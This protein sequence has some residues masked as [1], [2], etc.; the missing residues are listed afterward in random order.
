MQNLTRTVYGS[1]LQSLELLGGSFQ[2]T[3]YT[4]LNEKFAI[5]GGV[6][7]AS[8]PEFKGWVIGNGGHTT[9][10]GT[11]NIPI[12]TPLQHEATDPCCFHH[13][14]FVLRELT[15]DLTTAQ[16]A[17]YALRRIEEW[18]GIAYAAY[19]A[20]R[21]DSSSI[22]PV[23]QIETVASDGTATDVV[24]APDST[25]LSPTAKQLSATGVNVATGQLA[26][27]TS[28]LDLSLDAFDITELLN[29][30]NVIYG[31]TNYAIISE[32]GLI[33]GVDK[34]ISASGSGA[35]TF[36]FNE[37]IAAQVIEF[38]NCMYPL[39]YASTGLELI[40][41]VGASEPLLNISNTTTT[42]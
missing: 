34:T 25:N 19:Y 38:V 17:N 41:D 28:Q 24:F 15:N 5:E 10:V 33:S 2:L 11:N 26:K 40:L 27:V 30:A 3:P 16:Q 37:L 23:I 32:I 21:Q 6:V 1:Y 42:S 31:D 29:A 13:L 12:S 4:T 9:T 7:P 36:N 8:V 20:K 35:S 14:P 22:A 39:V 18:N